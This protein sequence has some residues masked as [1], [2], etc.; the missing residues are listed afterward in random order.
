MTPVGRT[1]EVVRGCSI[2]PGQLRNH[3]SALDMVFPRTQR[4]LLAECATA[5]SQHVLA[6]WL[7]GF[8]KEQVARLHTRSEDD[9]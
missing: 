9:P 3:E 1:I 6:C 8:E 7:A 2:Q 5:G 4:Q